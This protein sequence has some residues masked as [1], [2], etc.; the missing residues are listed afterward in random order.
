M[1]VNE[2]T[3]SEEEQRIAKAAFQKAY[4]RETD[5]LVQNMKDYASS[6][7]DIDDIWRLHD[8]LSAKRHDI[9]GKYGNYDYGAVLFIFSRFVKDG[10]LTLEDLEGLETSKIS[11]VSVLARM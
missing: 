6:V 3:W 5:A 1:K 4:Q 11:K 10:W 9:D 7:T 2:V 8:F